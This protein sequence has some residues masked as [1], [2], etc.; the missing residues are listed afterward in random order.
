MQLRDR[1]EGWAAGLYLAALTLR[2]RSDPAAFIHDFTGNDRHVVDYLSAEVLVGQPEKTRNFLL[3][4]SILDRFCA[5]LCDAVTQRSDS[6][7]TLRELEA[8]N[9]FLVPLDTKREWYTYH[10]LFGELLRQELRLVESQ[11]IPELHRRACAWH[12]ESGS[13]SDAIHHATAA[14]EIASASEMILSHWLEARDRARLVIAPDS[15]PSSP[16]SA[17]SRWKRSRE[18]HVFALS[19]PPRSRSRAGSPKPTSGSRPLPAGR[20]TRS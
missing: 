3:Q 11:N 8:S 12:R 17:D 18:M 10:H 9:F 15:K 5:S 19:R 2:G 14:G 16:G 7:Q 4:T 13:V 1:T 6:R 20:A